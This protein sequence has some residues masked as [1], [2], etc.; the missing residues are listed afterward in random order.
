MKK[1]CGIVQDLLPLYLDGVC[2][3]ESRS[4]VEEHLQVCVG[5][6]SMRKELQA[7]LPI[8][9]GKMQQSEVEI[10]KKTSWN[11]SKKAVFR[12]F[13]ITLIVIYWLVYFC[14][15][16][17][18]DRGDYR[19]FS[20]SFHEVYGIGTIVIPIVTAVWLILVLITAIRT[21]SWKKYAALFAVLL[22]LAGWQG[23]ILYEQSRIVQVVCHTSVA[24]F[25]DET[26]VMIKNG[27]TPVILEVPPMLMNLLWGPSYKYWFYYETDKDDPKHGR[28]VNIEKV[29]EL[30]EEMMEQYQSV[31]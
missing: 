31:Q 6:R 10:L 25:L 19:Y 4:L 26:H 28:L 18:A 15:E 12:A 9:D 8:P 13:G 30:T 29:P 27:D 22:L 24:R 11:I 2:G 16:Y 21:K 3:E 20:Y 14:Q 17:L 23:K 5:C 7:E 1:Q